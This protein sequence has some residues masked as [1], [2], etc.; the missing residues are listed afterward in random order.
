MVKK[1]LRLALG[2]VL[3]FA[4]GCQQKCACETDCQQAVRLKLAHLTCSEGQSAEECEADRVEVYLGE[5]VDC[6]NASK[7]AFSD[8]W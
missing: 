5:M 7:G 1:V 6:I 4:G 2:G 8:G 3:M